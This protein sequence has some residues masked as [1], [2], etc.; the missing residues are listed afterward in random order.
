MTFFI[1]LPTPT[2]TRIIRIYFPT[3]CHVFK[4]LIIGYYQ[5]LDLIEQSVIRALVEYIFE[6]FLETR[7]YNK[8]AQRLNEE[9]YRTKMNADFT[10]LAVKDL[11]SNSLTDS[12]SQVPAMLQALQCLSQ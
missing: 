11:I 4:K 9:G 5:T 12:V 3:F 10:T 2:G 8:T 6:V 7:S 1:L